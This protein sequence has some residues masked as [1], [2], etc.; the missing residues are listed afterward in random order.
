VIII[1]TAIRAQD[2]SAVITPV[3]GAMV[4]KTSVSFLDRAENLPANSPVTPVHWHVNPVDKMATRVQALLLH[5]EEE[6]A[7]DTL[8]ILVPLLLLLLLPLSL[9]SYHKQV[10][11]AISTGQLN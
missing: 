4:K 3:V 8:P 1:I 9:A 10:G 6:V 5:T 7:L 2:T 11:V